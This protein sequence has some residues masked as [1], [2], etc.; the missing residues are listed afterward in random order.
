MSALSDQA[1]FMSKYN[2]QYQK[3]FQLK[4]DALFRMPELKNIYLFAVFTQ[5]IAPVFYRIIIVIIIIIIIINQG[6]VVQS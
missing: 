1:H 4:C 3:L 2:L 6:P 5:C